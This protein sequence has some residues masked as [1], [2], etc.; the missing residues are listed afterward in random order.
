MGLRF[1]TIMFWRVRFLDLAGQG[2]RG[3]MKNKEAD[4][5]CKLCPFRSFARRSAL[6]SHVEKYHTRETQFVTLQK[7]L[8]LVCAMYEQMQ[9]GSG[10]IF[11]RV[12]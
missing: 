1:W 7:Q 10:Q 6:L 12:H 11:A 8:P 3:N 4:Y 9:A 2:V 5:S